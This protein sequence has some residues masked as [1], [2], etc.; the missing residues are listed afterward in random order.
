PQTSTAQK[1]GT[2]RIPGTA[3]PRRVTATVP[4]A[5]PAAR[6]A[7]ARLTLVRI[8]ATLLVDCMGPPSCHSARR[9]TAESAERARAHTIRTVPASGHVGQAQRRER[10]EPVPGPRIPHV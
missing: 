7:G 9:V 6:T 8:C 10:G 5:T 1:P 3:A 2:A 4:L